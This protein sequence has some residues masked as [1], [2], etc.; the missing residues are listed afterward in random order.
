MKKKFLAVNVALALG[1]MSGLA[2][3]VTLPVPDAVINAVGTD[4]PNFAVAKGNVVVADDH[5]GTINVVPYYSVQNGNTVSL[6]ITN[7][8]LLNGKAVKVRF[9]GAQWSDD[10]LDF[11]VFLSPHDVWTAAITQG[12]DGVARISTHGAAGDQS[13]TLPLEIVDQR[14]VADVRLAANDVGG[15]LEGYVEIITTADIPPVLNGVTGTGTLDD[16]TFVTPAGGNG[17]VTTPNWLYNIIKHS[18]KGAAPKC[19][20]ETAAGNALLN[21]VEDNYWRNSASAIGASVRAN[22]LHLYQT[23]TVTTQNSNNGGSSYKYDDT[24]TSYQFGTDF[25]HTTDDWLQ[26]PTP[27]I[28]TSVT[29]INVDNLRAYTL[30]ATAL[31]NAVAITG[32][33]SNDP[34]KSLAAQNLVDSQGWGAIKTYFQQRGTELDAVTWSPALTADKIFGPIGTGLDEGGANVRLVQWDLPDLSTPTLGEVAKLLSATSG[35]TNVGDATSGVVSAARYPGGAATAQRD[36]VSAALQAP[37]F[38]FDYVTEPDIEGST[39][40][41][42]NQPLRRY[43]Y[44]Y[45]HQ[46]PDA[47]VFHR[48]FVDA[49]LQLDPDAKFKIWGEVNTPYEVLNGADNSIPLGSLTIPAYFVTGREEERGT[50]PTGGVGFSPAPIVPGARA[51]LFGEVSV[52]SINTP[53]NTDSGALSAKLTVNHLRTGYNNGWG[54]YSTASISNRAA[55]HPFVPSGAAGT[56]GLTSHPLL[57]GGLHSG[58]NSPANAGR[59]LPFIAY[60]AVNVNSPDKGHQAYG[61]TLPVRKGPQINTLQ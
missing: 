41:V 16:S 30:Q 47:K 15:T 59:W 57:A 6:T 51:G 61:T 5:I 8:D 56:W 44:W 46:D 43:F 45:D 52:I 32:D 53:D 19:R 10:V 14:F 24:H 31:K 7:N 42:V 21:L 11:Q 34:V 60:G 17:N 37:G 48:Q 29:V 38:A 25:T 20:T 39:D 55:G 35:T 3:A 33:D 36:L 4:S 12:A 49:D 1:A 13:C 18:D 58:E 40:I 22:G 23:A 2:A 26:F 50:P 28:S 9:R 54:W 27:G